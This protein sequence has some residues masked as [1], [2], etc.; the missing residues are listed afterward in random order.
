MSGRDRYFDEWPENSPI[1]WWNEGRAKLNK[2]I[3]LVNEWTLDGCPDGDRDRILRRI[4][5]GQQTFA[6]HD[7][8]GGWLD[9]LTEMKA[10]VSER[11]RV[12][13]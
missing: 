13:T 6:S 10:Y 2:I 8:G 5:M 12:K 11:S 9:D 1:G 3:S 7:G 4:E